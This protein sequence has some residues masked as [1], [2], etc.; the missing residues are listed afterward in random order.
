MVVANY[1]VHRKQAFLCTGHLPPVQQTS[2]VHRQSQECVVSEVTPCDER[3]IPLRAF[4][5]S[6][7]RGGGHAGKRW[8]TRSPHSEE[9]NGG[10]EVTTKSAVLILSRQAIAYHQPAA[11][12][13]PAQV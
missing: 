11:L 5:S 12:F 13:M 6:P 4:L 10:T 9:R 1:M 8:R 3:D 7:T 2:E